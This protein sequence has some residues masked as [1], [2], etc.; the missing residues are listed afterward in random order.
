MACLDSRSLNFRFDGQQF[1]IKMR[2]AGGNYA[3]GRNAKSQWGIRS[4]L[5]I[6]G[7]LIGS[8]VFFLVGFPDVPTMDEGRR[9]VRPLAYYVC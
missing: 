7:K 6:R 1:A 4:Y 3:F 9:R 8:A 5:F 2:L